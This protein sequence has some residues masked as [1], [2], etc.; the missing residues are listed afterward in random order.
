MRNEKQEWRKLL[1]TRILIVDDTANLRLLYRIELEA[2]GYEIIAVDSGTKALEVL[3]R[4]KI[5]AIVLDLL[6]PDCFG[7]ELLEKILA[8]ARHVPLVINTAYGQFCD[9]FQTWGAEA[10][11]VKSSDLSELKRVLQRILAGRAESE[12]RNGNQETRPQHPAGKKQAVQKPPSPPPVA[13]AQK[14]YNRVAP[15]L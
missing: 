1:M 11:I 15:P 8:R 9:N 14:R 13:L 5:D 2:E 12:M 6:L 10:F 3:A 7:L 4:E